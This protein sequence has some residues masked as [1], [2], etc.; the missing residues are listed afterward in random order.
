MA[1]RLVNMAVGLAMIPLLI[2]LL[3]GRGFAAW[4]ILLSCSAVFN[5]LQ[6]GMHT[7]LVRGVAVTNR[8]HP[9]AVAQLW[10]SAVAFLVAI[11]AAVLP[12]V[13]LGAWPLGEWLRL[14]NV[15]RWQPGTAILV[16][17]VAVA[18]RAVLITGTFTLFASAR[19]HQ[20]AALSLAQALASNTTATLAAWLTRDLAYTLV[21]FWVV[22]LLVVSTGF[23]I[24][25]RLGSRPRPSLVSGYLIR[26][27]LAYGVKVQLSEWAQTINFQFDKF[28]I[29]RVLG[30]WPAALYEVANRSVLA[31]RSIPSSGVDT[32]L[33]IAT[34]WAAAGRSRDDA[35]RRMALL[36]FYGSVVFFAGPLAV[37]PVFLYAWV[38]EMGY[39][40]RHVFTYLVVGAAAN[41]LALP[42]A[43]L[44]QAAGR[45]EVQARA[46]MVSIILNIPLSLTLVRVWGVEGGALASSLAM[47]L[48]MVILMRE[49][50]AALGTEAVSAVSVTVLRHWP[51]AAVCLG[52][53]GAVHF[54]F[55]RWLVTTPVHLRYGLRLRALAGVAALA[56]Y[57][58]CLLIVLLVKLRIGFE[59]DESQFLARL[60]AI[61]G[62]RRRAVAPEVPGPAA[63]DGTAAPASRSPPQDGRA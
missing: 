40:S 37:A 12:I 60:V 35:P 13:V 16:V 46:A 1:A 49:A 25:Q 52:W 19:F 48:G 34:Q 21:S 55:G 3:G 18:A 6:L 5:E 24:A 20:A 45:P 17:F 57:G 9:T 32:F 47:I 56:L 31:L 26:R 59:A 61:A 33:P 15:G 30:L 41:L 39:I 54:F 53:G 22:Q 7:A 58:A 28:V 43:T 23:V 50:R 29:V 10:S 4:A 38:G 42:L 27:L 44:A 14:P 63:L 62:S 2:H 8:G 36:A 11:H 51:L